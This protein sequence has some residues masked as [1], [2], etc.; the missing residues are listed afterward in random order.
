MKRNHYARKKRQLRNLAKKLHHLMMENSPNLGN[1]R[2]KIKIKIRI[3]L[4]EL[5][6]IFSKGDIKRVLGGLAI[7]LGLFYSSGASAQS[8]GV[9]VKN[10]FGLVATQENAMPTFVDL[11]GDGDMDLLVGEYYGSMQYFENTG[12]ATVPQFGAPV[13]NPYGI[14]ATSNISFPT[15]ADLDND[16]DMDLLVGEYGGTFS[17][18]ENTGSATNPQFATPTTN[19]FGLTPSYEFAIPD[20]ADIDGDGDMDLLVGE[21]YGNM[22]YYENT[23]SNSNPQFAAP[24][25][26]PF[27]LSATNYIACPSV[28]DIDNDGDLDVLV[29]E[30]NGSFQYFANTGSSTNPQFDSPIENPFGLQSVDTVSLPAMTD[31]DG[32]GD[33][34]LLVGEYYG[35]FRYFKNNLITGVPDLGKEV[36]LSMYPNPVSDILVLDTKE[37]I[38]RVEIFN[39][40]GQSVRIDNKPTIEV[41]TSQLNSGMYIIKIEFSSGNYSVNNFQKY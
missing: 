22:Q 15:F 31:L 14:V 6:G 28:E 35:N 16:G 9:P 2:Q 19:P 30:A 29:G 34:D 32:D 23:G 33:M 24:M 21:Y 25:M 4:N 38:K 36:P 39:L 20:F 3:I 5:S 37:P 8:F 40:L 12:S 13:T 18:F 1:E 7:T 26:N 27:G 10:P 41:N 11:D 17:Y